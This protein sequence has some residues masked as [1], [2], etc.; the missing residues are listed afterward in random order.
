MIDVQIIDDTGSICRNF[1]KTDLS[2]SIY[3]DKVK[4]LAAA[5]RLN[6]SFIILNYGL[7]QKGTAEFIAFLH[8]ACLNSKVLLIAPDLTDEE[9]IECIL[10]G[11][12]GYLQ[13]NQVGQFINKAI[14]VLNGGEAWISRRLTAALLKRLHTQ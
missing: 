3:D 6:P 10:A 2:V 12:L 14:T 9:A 7:C 13:S 1:D 4:A 11:A 5:E 8:A